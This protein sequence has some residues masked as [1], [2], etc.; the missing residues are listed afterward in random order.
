VDRSNV[1]AKGLRTGT[2]IMRTQPPSLN[3]APA[4]HPGILYSHYIAAGMLAM[5]ALHT[6][7]TVID[8]LGFTSMT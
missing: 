6:T 2:W 7:G 8:A 3:T 5:Q 4:S 1:T